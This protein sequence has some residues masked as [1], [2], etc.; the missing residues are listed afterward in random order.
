MN[1]IALAIVAVPI[2]RAC[3]LVER[4]DEL[5]ALSEVLVD[6]GARSQYGIPRRKLE[7]VGIATD[8]GIGTTRDESGEHDVVLPIPGHAHLDGGDRH[9]LGDVAQFRRDALQRV[10]GEA[11][12]VADLGM[13]QGAGQFVPERLAQD[14][15]VTQIDSAGL[16]TYAPSSYGPAP[17]FWW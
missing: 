12:P 15:K 16:K 2:R 7:Q 5:Q 6:E 10:V 11:D 13:G 17:D 8:Q 1:S 3:V 4:C 14:G 9:P